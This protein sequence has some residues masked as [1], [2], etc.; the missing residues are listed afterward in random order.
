MRKLIL[1]GSLAFLLSACASQPVATQNVTETVAAPAVA[2]CLVDLAAAR[3]VAPDEL[4]IAGF[5]VVNWNIRKGWDSDWATDLRQIHNGPDLLILQEA[6]ARSDAWDVVAPGHFRSFAEGFGFGK[7][8]TGV[9]TTSAAEPL[10]ECKLIAFEP[11]FGT[12]KAT[13]ITEYALMYS[14]ATLLVVNIHGI[15][16]TFGVRHMREQ[17]EQV[18]TIVSR[19][20][21]PVVFSGDFNTWHGRRA[22]VVEEIV[23]DLGLVAV[24][25]DADHRKKFFGRALDQI[26][27]RGL[28]AVHATSTA[29]ESS[30]HN[31]MSVEFR[32]D[33]RLVAL[34]AGQ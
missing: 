2:E 3:D 6:P 23:K 5:S 29:L 32:L 27:V 25:F 1:T 21:G 28:D 19:H 13:L 34:R 33:Q 20:D 26:Y 30:D 9:M 11:W 4:D 10:A 14:P 16:F 15:N 22:A 24:D 12:R 17:L 8:V 31:P 18:A 7:A